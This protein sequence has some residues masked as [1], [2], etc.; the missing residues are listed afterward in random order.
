[1]EALGS[2][3]YSPV[4]T[5]PR[6]YNFILF[7]LDFFSFVAGIRALE[8]TSFLLDRDDLVMKTRIGP[9]SSNGWNELTIRV[10]G[11][12]NGGEI[13]ATTIAI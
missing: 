5:L 3:F 10:S 8:T 9:C 6:V 7:G 2:L 13:T 1:M 11:K 4:E 12:K